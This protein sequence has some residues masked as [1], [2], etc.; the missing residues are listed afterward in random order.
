MDLSPLNN[1]AWHAI[2]GS[3]RHLAECNGAGGRYHTDVSPFGGVAGPEGLAALSGLMSEG[4]TVLLAWSSTV[5]TPVADDF[6]VLM[7]VPV[8]QMLCRTPEM[9]T[10]SPSSEV[11]IEVLGDSHAE[12]MVALAALTEPGPFASNTHRL[13]RYYGVFHDGALVAM[14]GE[15]FTLAGF[16]EVSGVCT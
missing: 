10:G 16:V 7:S 12:E 9:T 8:Y 5:A 14:A 15:R 4:D 13:G 2:A 3:H 1:P 11:D 6:E